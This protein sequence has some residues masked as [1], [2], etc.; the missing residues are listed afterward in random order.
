MYIGKY[1]PGC[2]GGPGNQPCALARCSQNHGSIDYCFQ[3]EEYPCRRYEGIEFLDSFILHRN[4]VKDLE[5]AKKMGISAY[6]TELEEK[7]GILQNL[8]ENYNDGR[9]K[10]FFCLAVN[11]LE[12]RYLKDIFS[13]IEL[14]SDATDLSIKEK[15]RAAERLFNEFAA[16]H[17]LKL[18]LNKKK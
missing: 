7:T 2:G 11:L 13:K 12:F 9:H 14:E 6:H 3:C 18:K 10:S 4:Q 8:L 15:A 1:C 5:K 17:D 16:D